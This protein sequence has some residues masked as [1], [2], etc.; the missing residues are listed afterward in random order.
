MLRRNA[1]CGMW[2]AELRK[3]LA[4]N[5]DCGIADCGKVKRAGNQAEYKELISK[6]AFRNFAFSGE[7]R[8]PIPQS[9]IRI[10][11]IPIAVRGRKSLALA[12]CFPAAKR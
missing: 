2:I 7:E 8:A 12:V 10:S 3:G 5:A 6:S 1:N 11:S 4:G 9:A